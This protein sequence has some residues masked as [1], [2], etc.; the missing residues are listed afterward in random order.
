MFAFLAIQV[1]FIIIVTLYSESFGENVICGLFN[2]INVFDIFA[3]KKN[4]TNYDVLQSIAFE[5]SMFK[6]FNFFLFF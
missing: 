2:L 4:A 3:E 6:N 5:I 1:Y